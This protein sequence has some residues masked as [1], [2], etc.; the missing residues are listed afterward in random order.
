MAAK[1]YKRRKRRGGG[2]FILSVLT[3]CVVVGAIITSLTVFLKVAEIEVSG[4]TRYEASDIIKTSGIQTGDNMFMINKFD[5]AEK[6]L[7][8]YPYIEQIKIRRRLP[9]VFTFEITERKP[10]AYI[11]SG[12]SRWLIDKNAYILQFVKKDEEINFPKIT[13]AEVVTPRAGIRLIL[14]NETQLPVLCEVLSALDG[15]EISS[16][17][18]RIEIDKLYDINLIYGDRFRV[19]MGDT[20]SLS[21]KVE[22]LR[23][24]VAELSDFDKGTINVSAVKEAR[25]KPNSSI[26]L[27]EKESQP[28]TTQTTPERDL[29]DEN[30]A[31][32]NVQE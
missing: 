31:E 1:R 27:S 7:D 8:E 18:K 28:E 30:S 15:T 4:T 22:M 29:S 23:A 25:F 5:V 6:I 21:K 19:V 20:S 17:V 2:G 16:S 26:D 11:M 10:A 3:F 13:G 9:D 32:E 14:K 24:V 12:E